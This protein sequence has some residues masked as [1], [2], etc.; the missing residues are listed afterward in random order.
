[1]L[2]RTDHRTE[3]YHYTHLDDPR[4]LFDLLLSDHTV[5]VLV[6]KA[7]NDLEKCF[8]EVVQ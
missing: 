4:D 5:S 6:I 1:M 2:V 7:E 3:D 8:T